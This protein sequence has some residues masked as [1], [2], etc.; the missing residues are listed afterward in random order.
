M[1][2][3]EGSPDLN[4]EKRYNDR[5]LSLRKKV[6]CIKHKIP[7]NNTYEKAFE[8]LNNK[9]LRAMEI[10]Q[11]Q[12][13]TNS[14]RVLTM[15][16][17][18]QVFR[19]GSSKLMQMIKSTKQRK[20]PIFENEI[21]VERTIRK[22]DLNTLAQQQEKK[23]AKHVLPKL[24]DYDEQM[25]TRMMVKLNTKHLNAIVTAVTDKPVKKRMPDDFATYR[26]LTEPNV[27]FL[28]FYSKN[29]YLASLNYTFRNPLE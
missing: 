26:L 15:E 28:K 7:S 21:D 14:K 5:Q 6:F 18:P 17:Y 29:S 3:T 8:L 2:R 20:N 4:E 13:Y 16:N 11:K 12:N 27:D 22:I 25:K 24:Y 10:E 1:S 23:K 9:I 19:N